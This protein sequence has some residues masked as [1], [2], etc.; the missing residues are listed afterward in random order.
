MTIIDQELNIGLSGTEYTIDFGICGPIPIKTINKDFKD[1]TFTENTEITKIKLTSNSFITDELVCDEGTDNSTDNTK[2]TYEAK[3]AGNVG[4]SFGIGFLIFT[5]VV[6][7]V[8]SLGFKFKMNDGLFNGWDKGNFNGNLYILSLI[9]M[10]LLSV[11][12]FMAYSGILSWGDELFEYLTTEQRDTILSAL[13]PTAIIS[14]LIFVFM[15][16]YKMIV[17]TP[18]QVAQQV[19]N[20]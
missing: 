11:S 1:G 16:G 15:A 19:A 14:F 17:M 7:G 6:W 2:K 12:C 5:L 10:F 4:L 13:L 20:T 18:K 8:T 9:I 3:I